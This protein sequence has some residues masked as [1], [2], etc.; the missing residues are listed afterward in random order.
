MSDAVELPDQAAIPELVRKLVRAGH[1]S[2]AKRQDPG[3]IAKAITRMKNVLRGQPAEEDRR[4][5]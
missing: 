3:A 1:L 5:V 2:P 4:A